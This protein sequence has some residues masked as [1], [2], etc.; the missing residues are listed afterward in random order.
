L[1]PN[2][3]IVEQSKPEDELSD[4]FEKL[5]NLSEQKHEINE[6]AAKIEAKKRLL[7][8]KIR[9]IVKRHINSGKLYS[10]FDPDFIG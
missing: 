5:N 7:R 4:S 9:A 6:R 10:G 8:S 2:R 1:E 3:A